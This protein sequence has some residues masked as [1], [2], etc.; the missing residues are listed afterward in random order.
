MKNTYE[1]FDENL[2]FHKGDETIEYNLEQVIEGL[3][4]STE[5][6]IKEDSGRLMEFCTFE[7]DMTREEDQHWVA[8][9]IWQI[10]ESVRGLT[11]VGKISLIIQTQN[12]F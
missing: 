7:N 2:Y 9:Q 1:I 5:N 12:R 10:E 6:R 8:V 11:Q 4:K 3:E